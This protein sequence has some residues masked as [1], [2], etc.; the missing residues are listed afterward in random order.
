MGHIQYYLQYKDQPVIYREGA[1]PGMKIDIRNTTDIDVYLM[2]LQDLHVHTITRKNTSETPSCFSGFH[3]AVG[4]VIALSVATPKHLRV[5]GL[6]E[7]GPD[8]MESNIN[9]LF[10]MVSHFRLT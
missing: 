10:K 7:D 2:Y 6:L 3:E 8:D 1:N 5:M 4:D 9:Q